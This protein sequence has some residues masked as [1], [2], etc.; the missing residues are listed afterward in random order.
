MN[1]S[2]PFDP[3]MFLQSTI[4]TAFT[5]RPPLPPGDYIAK[6]RDFN[7]KT[8][9]SGDREDGSGKWYSLSLQL[10]VDLGP[11]PEAKQICQVDSVILFPM[12][13]IDLT[14]AGTFDSGKDKNR[15]LRMYRDALGQ[16]VGGQR[17]SPSM[18]QG[19]LLRVK[20]DQEPYQGEIRETVK[21]VSAI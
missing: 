1:D 14:P 21:A 19:Q 9:K 18:M 4:D 5:K 7:E 2:T 13:F 12:L 3:M 17:W 6:I 16:N 8:V 11:Y 10:E 20:V 15:N